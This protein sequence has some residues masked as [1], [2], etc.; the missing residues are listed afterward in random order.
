MDTEELASRILS[1]SAAFRA[2]SAASRA[3]SAASLA[4]RSDRN[5][6]TASASFM[7]V[8][9]LTDSTS[10]ACHGAPEESSPPRRAA[11]VG[12]IRR[13]ENTS[14][15]ASVTLAS[16][17]MCQFRSECSRSFEHHRATSTS[18]TGLMR[19]AQPLGAWSVSLACPSKE[20]FLTFIATFEMPDFE[21]STSTGFLMWMSSAK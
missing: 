5:W 20:V 9:E 13:P 15:S 14:R 18:I 19:H 12:T 6:S 1:A 2:A 16:S 4:A 11:S 17:T 21:I 3:A 7:A 10:D 8:D